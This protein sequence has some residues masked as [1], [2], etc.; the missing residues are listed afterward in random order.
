M[1]YVLL[2][3]TLFHFY[4]SLDA[5]SY[6]E[7]RNIPAAFNRKTL[8]TGFYQITPICL[9]HYNQTHNTKLMLRDLID[10]FVSEAVARWYIEW[11]YKSLPPAKNPSSALS[12]ILIAYNWG[13]GNTL[14]WLEAGADKTKLPS[15]TREYLKS[16]DRWILNGQSGATTETKKVSDFLPGS[17]RD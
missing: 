2:A 15:E 3:G 1:K 9:K 7:S 17:K 6:I 12:Q 14:K 11:L 10:P 4:V 5:I 13:I 16:Y 8:A